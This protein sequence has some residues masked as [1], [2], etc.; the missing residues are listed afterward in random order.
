MIL[1]KEAILILV[2]SFIDKYQMAKVI[3]FSLIFEKQ[4]KLTSG[5][6]CVLLIRCKCHRIIQLVCKMGK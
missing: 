1:E 2:A 3:S 6:F 5:I 4:Y